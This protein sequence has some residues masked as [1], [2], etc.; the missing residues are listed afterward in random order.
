MNRLFGDDNNTPPMLPHDDEDDVGDQPTEPDMIPSEPPT[1]TL[2]TLSPNPPASQLPREICNLCSDLA[3]SLLGPGNCQTGRERAHLMSDD[4][5]TNPENKEHNPYEI[6]QQALK[7]TLP[8]FAL[9]TA[10]VT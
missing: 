7:Q 3:P 4:P 5:E 8:A 2:P 1:A 9:L 10:A 6:L